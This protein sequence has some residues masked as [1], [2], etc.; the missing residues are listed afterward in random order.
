M[1]PHPL[2]LPQFTSIY[3]YLAL[4]SPPYPL[5]SLQSHSDD[6]LVRNVVTLMARRNSAKLDLLPK[7][8][9]E[10]FW[11]ALWLGIR[12]LLCFIIESRRIVQGWLPVVE[13]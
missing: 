6:R 12:P 4:L 11:D 8:P 3:L 13:N 5:W 10:S 2:C 7:E 1:P 9:I